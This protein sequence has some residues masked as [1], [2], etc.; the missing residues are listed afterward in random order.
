MQGD[1]S[2][3]ET[4]VGNLNTTKANQ[5]TIAPFFSAETEYS[6]DDLVYYN[7]LLYS[8]I[9]DHLGEWD[10]SDFT[11]TTVARELAS[12][13]V[14]VNYSTTEQNTG[15]KWIDGKDIYQKTIAFD[16]TNSQVL[17]IDI[18]SIGVDRIIKSEISGGTSNAGY[19]DNCGVYYMDSSDYLNIYRHTQGDVDEIRVRNGSQWFKTENGY[20]T[21]WYTKT[22][23]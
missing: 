9:F 4:D 21:I 5:I 20:F 18:S 22:T 10:A 11:P 13:V 19:N 12:Q 23:T 7:G 1:V 14:G 15:I 2:E 6:V 8:C 17:N 16:N 3:L